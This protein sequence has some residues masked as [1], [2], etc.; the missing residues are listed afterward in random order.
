MLGIMTAL[1]VEVPRDEGVDE[2]IELIDEGTLDVGRRLGKEGLGGLLA[3]R[4]GGKLTTVMGLSLDVGRVHG[5]IGAAKG[6]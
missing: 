1:D 4:D 2:L 5:G 3:D 6:G